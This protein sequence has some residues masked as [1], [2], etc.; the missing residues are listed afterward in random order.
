MGKRSLR[1]SPSFPRGPC[2][3]AFSKLSSPR[4]QTAIGAL[5]GRA[6]RGPR[7]IRHST[8]RMGTREQTKRVF[9]RLVDLRLCARTSAAAPSREKDASRQFSRPAEAT[10][11]PS[12]PPASRT[13]PPPSPAR[14]SSSHAHPHPTGSCGFSFSANLLS[15]VFFHHKTYEIKGY[16][17]TSLRVL[18]NVAET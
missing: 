6:C 12:H 9:T 8:H 11:C 10:P 2:F 7:Y 15:R 13:R 1:F 17:D 4:I 3:T 16:N 14:E 5:Q 18:V